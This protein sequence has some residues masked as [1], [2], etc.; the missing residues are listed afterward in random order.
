MICAASPLASDPSP[1][2]N[3]RLREAVKHGSMMADWIERVSRN[4]FGSDFDRAWH[5]L[6]ENPEC[7]YAADFRD[8]LTRK[9]GGE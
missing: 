4:S 7:G 6:D 8:A 2:E 1:D 9:E 3:K 5:D